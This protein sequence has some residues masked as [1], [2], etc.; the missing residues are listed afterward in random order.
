MTLNQADKKF[1]NDVINSGSFHSYCLGFEE[2]G[3]ERQIAEKKKSCLNYF[4]QLK[5]YRL[6]LLIMEDCHL[7]YHLALVICLKKMSL[8]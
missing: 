4:Q 8:M 6:A 2:E 5:Q 7:G 3:E 1:N